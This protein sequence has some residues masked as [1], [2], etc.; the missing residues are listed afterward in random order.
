MA[1]Y[2]NNIMKIEKGDPLVVWDAIRSEES[3]F[4]F[5]KLVPMPTEVG[6][7][8]SKEL[9]ESPFPFWYAWCCKHWGT[10]K[11]AISAE[12]ELSFR[13][14]YDCPEPIF[15]L[16]AQKFPEHEITVRAYAHDGDFW[17]VTYTLKNGQL[18]AVEEEC[19]CYDDAPFRNQ[20]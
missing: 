4:D 7:F 8:E 14:A 19:H 3:L 5:K 2:V 1:N 11:N 16:L 17:H 9:E 15:E 6:E 13:T 10:K 12:Y 20:G 18:T